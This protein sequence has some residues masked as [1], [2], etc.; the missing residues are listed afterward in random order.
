MAL[1]NPQKLIKIKWK[2]ESESESESENVYSI[3]LQWG[4]S[5]Y[6]HRQCSAYAGLDA[7]EF[8]SETK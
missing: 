4:V 3:Y 6:I 7:T 2:A 1:H 8:I 5:D